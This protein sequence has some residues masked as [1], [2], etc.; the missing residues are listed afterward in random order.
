MI[1]SEEDKQALLDEFGKKVIKKVRDSSLE[2]AMG[3]AK[4]TTTNVAKRNEY[5]MLSCLTIE[6]QEA[7]CNLVS[8]VIT[9]VIYNFL[10]MFE[11]NNDTMHL[12]LKQNG[13]TYDMVELSEKMGSEIA[14]IDDD[15]WIQ[16]FSKIGRFVL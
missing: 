5:H 16:R 4:Y 13:E 10:E 1:L 8:E 14:C 2:Y 3:I 11:E 15:G 7:I 6:Q 9:D 12:L